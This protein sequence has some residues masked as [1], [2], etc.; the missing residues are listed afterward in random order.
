M[1]TKDKVNLANQEGQ[2]LAVKYNADFVRLSFE[3]T[4][5]LLRTI[6]KYISQMLES[7]YHPTS[8]IGEEDEQH[9]EG[10]YELNYISRDKQREIEE[11]EANRPLFEEVE[12]GSLL[13]RAL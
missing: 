4:G 6:S 1:E 11:D 7:Y 5:E 13:D 2:I 8:V 12:P 10:E 9:D 3:N